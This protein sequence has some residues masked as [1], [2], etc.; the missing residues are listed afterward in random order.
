MMPV[1]GREEAEE[2]DVAQFLEASGDVGK[3]G[4]E[5]MASPEGS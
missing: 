4:P 3:D 2:N 1:A 5:E